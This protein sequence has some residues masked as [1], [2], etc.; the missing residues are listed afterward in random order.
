MTLRQYEFLHPGYYTT[1]RVKEI[2]IHTSKKSQSSQKT[3]TKRTWLRQQSL[4]E[5]RG[6]Y[7]L[8]IGQKLTKK[9]TDE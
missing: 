7:R 4:E 9:T 2:C 3:R 1:T 5:K 6:S 8:G